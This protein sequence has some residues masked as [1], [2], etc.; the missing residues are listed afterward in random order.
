MYLCLNIN[1][2]IHYVVGN[3]CVKVWATKI[4]SE[5]QHYLEAGEKEIEGRCV[6][7][8]AKTIAGRYTYMQL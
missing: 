3:A 5:F 1:Y 2:R 8:L 7:Y 6:L 4:V